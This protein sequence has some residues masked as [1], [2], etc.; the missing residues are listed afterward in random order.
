MTGVLRLPSAA[1]LRPR[2]RLRLR[3]H[4]RLRLRLTCDHSEQTEDMVRRG[5]DRGS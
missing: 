5:G 2:P 3:L 1:T 4:P